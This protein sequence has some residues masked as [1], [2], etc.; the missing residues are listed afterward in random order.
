MKLFTQNTGA[1]LSFI[2]I[3]DKLIQPFVLTPVINV[4]TTLVHSLIFSG[5][6]LTF[7]T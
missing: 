5:Q 7:K 4:E 3:K 2:L 1:A 6:K